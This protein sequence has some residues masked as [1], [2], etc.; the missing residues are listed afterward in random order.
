MS[1]L[2]Q[3]FVFPIG[4]VIFI[5]TFPW[6]NLIKLRLIIQSQCSENL[7]KKENYKRN[8]EGGRNSLSISLVG[9]AHQFVLQ[10][11]MVNPWKYTYKLLC[12]DRAVVLVDLGV[13]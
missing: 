9:R 8:D 7:N 10:Y 11:Q 5:L 3:T 4:N 13:C 2:C 12:T 6:L 1:G